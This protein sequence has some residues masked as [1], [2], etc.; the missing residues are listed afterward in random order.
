MNLVFTADLMLKLIAQILQHFD[1][2]PAS[3]LA[4]SILAD[5]DSSLPP[6]ELA[7]RLI[8]T[9]ASVTGLVDSLERRG[10]VTRRRHPT[11]RRM[12]LI[13]LTDTGRQVARE[14]RPIVHQHQKAWLEVLSP[15]E[16]SQLIES[17]H[18]LQASLKRE[19]EGMAAQN[20][21]ARG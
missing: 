20:K 14:F 13:E 17:L 21:S 15:E 1:L 18:R 2:S 11:D 16:Q 7:D 19:E 4:L 5:S 9:R 10:Y 8:I 6:N 12:L 3:G